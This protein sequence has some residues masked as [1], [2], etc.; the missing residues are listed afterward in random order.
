MK[1]LKFR[2][3]AV[4]ISV[5]MLAGLT[6]C[7]PARYDAKGHV[8][9][10]LDAQYKNILGDEYVKLVA[11][12]EE[13]LR[14]IYRNG[15][16]YEAEYLAYYFDIILE[17]CPEDIRSRLESVCEKMYNA[18]KYEVGDAADADDSYI[19]S[20]TVYPIDIIDHIV[21]EH[22][23][24]FE[25]KW[26]ERYMEFA[27]MTE[28][29]VESLWAEEILTLLEDNVKH[30]GYLEPE[31]ISVQVSKDDEGYYMISDDD[32]SRLNTLMIKY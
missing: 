15:I 2:I 26:T 12:S 3:S 11:N 27:D 31:T 28:D 9:G 6:G 30:I 1:K 5:F 24:D 13:E 14:Q 21:S 8:Q 18:A 17:K 20:V 16:E 29:E 4:I 25:E 7:G 22:W 23:D 10:D 19:V 32:F